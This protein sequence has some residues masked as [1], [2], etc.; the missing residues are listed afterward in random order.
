M[1]FKK[2]SLAALI[3]VAV[4]NIFFF[5]THIGVGTGLLF[6]AINLFLYFTRDKES[7]N[8]KLAIFS[9]I[10]SAV[11]AS[12]VGLMA[13]DIIQPLNLFLASFFATHAFYY[14]KNP[15]KFSYLIPEFIFLSFNTAAQAILSLTK[16]FRPEEELKTSV[17]KDTTTALIRGVLITIPIFAVLLFLL[18]SADVVFAKYA[19][20]ILES[21]GERVIVSLIIFIGL[22]TFGITKFAQKFIEERQ[23][24]QSFNLHKVYELSIITASLVTLFGLFI[25]VQVRYLFS[26]VGELEL[27]KLG[28]T[29][30]TYSEYVRKGFF[31]LLIASGVASVVIIYILHSVKFLSEKRKVLIQILS[32]LLTVEVGLVLFSAAQ[33]LNLY[34]L[35]HGLTRARIFGFIFLL[36][37]SAIL[38]IFFIRIIKEQKREWIFLTG[39]GL[40]VFAFVSLNFINIDGLIASKYKPTVNGETDYFY[41]TSLSADANNVWKEAIVDA[42]NQTNSLKSHQSLSTEDN[43]KLYWTRLAVNG[44]INHVRYLTD[45]YGPLNKV[46]AGS[47]VLP[48]EVLRQ[49]KWQ[50]YN[51]S[52]YKAYLDILQN[53]AFYSRLPRISSDLASLD[54]RVSEDVRRNTPLDRST[55]PPF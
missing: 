54:T 28:I 26:N 15:N 34:A 2:V 19:E 30:L 6:L 32:C 52:E 27:G 43:R 3:F 41:L 20:D 49:R 48:P 17:S 16:I 22:F 40:T 4:Y 13:N 1:D 45:K 42:E 37:L 47:R 8:L 51:L 25:L 12:L 7:K 18:S 35:A 21:L 33:R 9:S 39:L 5:Q 46:T 36:W 44:V 31:E 14:Y 55:D 23:A 29:S 24:E 10:T 38:I 11:F 53:D 50:S